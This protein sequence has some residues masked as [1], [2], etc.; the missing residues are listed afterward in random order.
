NA[1]R[2]EF[3]AIA[4]AMRARRSAL[5]SLVFPNEGAELVRPQ[6]RLAYHA[7]LE[8]FL[9]ACLGGRVEPVGGAFEGAEMIAY[10]GAA[11][12]PG[13]QAFARRAATPA[14]APTPTASE[15]PPPAAPTGGAGGPSE[16]FIEP[17]ADA[18]PAHALD[19]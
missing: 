5:V 9:G 2:A 14:A 15:P 18:E 19:P 17:P 3:D 1:S 11:A 4:Q 7:V 10:D 6:N 8:Q 13:L 16:D 12:V